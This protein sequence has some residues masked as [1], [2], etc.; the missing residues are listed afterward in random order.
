MNFVFSNVSLNDFILTQILTWHIKGATS[1]N[2][3]CVIRPAFEVT[4]GL[5]IVFEIFQLSFV[6]KETTTFFRTIVF[7]LIG[8]FCYRWNDG[9]CCETIESNREEYLAQP[10]NPRW[11]VQSYLWKTIFHNFIRVG[12]IYYVFA[13]L[14]FSA[15]LELTYRSISTGPG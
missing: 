13:E 5:R 4:I 8:G 1:T 12:R 15:L 14:P 11:G 3:N 2:T 9:H 10:W 6:T 7:D